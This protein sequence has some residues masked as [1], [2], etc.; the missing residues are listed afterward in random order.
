MFKAVR[1]AGALR[2]Q[3]IFSEFLAVGSTELEDIKNYRVACAVAG[4]DEHAVV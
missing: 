3:V 4:V 2:T 1:V